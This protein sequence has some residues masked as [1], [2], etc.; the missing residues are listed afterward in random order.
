MCDST[1]E[2]SKQVN[3]STNEWNESNKQVNSSINEWNKQVNDSTNEWNESNKQVNDPT[4]EPFPIK[5]STY[6]PI[7]SSSH[8]LY[9]H[10]YCVFSYKVNHSINPVWDSTHI[11]YAIQ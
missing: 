1:S 8:S 4:N 6:L 10:L 9:N 5:L 3:D 11:L 7:H 2:S